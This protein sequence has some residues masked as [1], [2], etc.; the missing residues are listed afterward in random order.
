MKISILVEGAT[1]IGFIR[2]VREFLAVR[3]PGK[4]PR[5]DPVPYDGR[6]P[7]GDRLRREV[8]NLLSGQHRADAV[9]ALTDVYTGTHDFHD[10]TDAKAKMKSWV[11]E[12]NRFYPHVALH[13]FETWLIPYWDEIQRLAGSNRQCP[14]THPENVNHNTPP[15]YVLEEVFRTGTKKQKY[16][17]TVHSARILKGKDIRI[18]AAACPELKAF[19]NTILTLAGADTI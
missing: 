18:A 7:T 15:A 3:L 4:M 2:S 14:S 17:K 19:L 10:A 8:A 5:L 13:D 1:E 9:I 11:G 12:E 6:I 16:R